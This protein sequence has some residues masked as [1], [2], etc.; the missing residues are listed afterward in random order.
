MSPPLFTAVQ[1]HKKRE[2]EDETAQLRGRSGLKRIIVLL[3]ADAQKIYGERGW[4]EEGGFIW[5]TLSSS[6]SS[7]LP[8]LPPPHTRHTSLAAALLPL[9]PLSLHKSKHKWNSPQPIQKE[10][11]LCLLPAPISL[12]LPPE[13]GVFLCHLTGNYRAAHTRTDVYTLATGF[14]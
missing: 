11:L 6:S 12:F 7:S 2:K 8:S 13:S 14:F 5:K 3:N 4:T 9:P 10:T 1:V